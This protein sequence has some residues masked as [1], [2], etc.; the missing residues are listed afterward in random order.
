MVL[1][2]MGFVKTYE[3]IRDHSV[4]IVE[5]GG[6]ESDVTEM[7]AR[8][9]I[10]KLVLFDYDRVQLANMNRIFNQLFTWFHAIV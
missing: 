7:Q 5:V 10:G 9:K 4:T 3:A 8:Y 1:K 6:K 2:R